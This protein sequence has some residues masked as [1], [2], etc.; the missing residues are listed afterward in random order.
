MLQ[1]LEVI[2]II[3]IALLIKKHFVSYSF[4]MICKNV[5]RKLFQSKI[6]DL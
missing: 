5:K 2:G 3:S 1:N 4:M 6:I